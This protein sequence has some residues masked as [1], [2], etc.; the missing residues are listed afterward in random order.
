MKSR[1]ILYSLLSLFCA[2]FFISFFVYYNFLGFPFSIPGLI[3]VS[4][5]WAAISLIPLSLF[6]HFGHKTLESQNPKKLLYQG[7]LIT[8]AISACIL[9]ILFVV[10][11]FM[12]GG[13]PPMSAIVILFGIPVILMLSILVFITSAVLLFFSGK[14]KIVVPIVLFILLLINIVPILSTRGCVKGDWYCLGTQAGITEDLSLCRFADSEQHDCMNQA[15]TVMAVRAKN[16]TICKQLPTGYTD[17]CLAGY[18][19]ET[20]DVGVC[21]EITTEFRKEKALKGNLC[22]KAIS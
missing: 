12:K 11:L 21:E 6:L 2:A 9:V 3:G 4:L 13:H 15:V 20:G 22:Y 16:P 5:F 14:L 18:A 19:Q 17:N 10:S 1:R 7:P 8:L